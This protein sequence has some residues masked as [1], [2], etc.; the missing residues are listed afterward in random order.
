MLTGRALDADAAERKAV[1]LRLR[2]GLAALLEILEHIAIGR[3]FSQRA[4]RAGAEHV[5]FSKQNLRVLMC[6]RLIL[7]RKVQ[8]NVRDLVSLEA[9]KRFKRD[10]IAVPD[11]R[12]PA[13][14]TEFLRKIKAAVVS[15]VF[16]EFVIMALIAPVMRRKGVDLRD[17]GHKCGDGRSDVR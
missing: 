13:V 2:Q 11:Q 6:V 12:N 10:V 9:Q 1:H 14:R 16:M 7:R 17:P 3:L 8:I 4:D 15:F 5:A